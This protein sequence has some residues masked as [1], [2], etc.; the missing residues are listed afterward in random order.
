MSPF[1]LILIIPGMHVFGSCVLAAFFL[2]P[3]VALGGIVL[4]VFGWYFLPFEALAASVIFEFYKPSI[5][6]NKTRTL[7]MALL[8]G[9]IGAIIFSPFVPKEEGSR[10]IDWIGSAFAGASSLLFAFVCIHLIKMKNIKKMD[11]NEY[12]I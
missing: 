11:E 6:K 5:V 10:I 12:S 1:W 2:G 8:V 3:S 7:K 9:A 4:S